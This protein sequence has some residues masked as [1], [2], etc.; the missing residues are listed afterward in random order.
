MKAFFTQTTGIGLLLFIILSIYNIVLDIED[1]M[2]YVDKIELIETQVKSIEKNS[3]IVLELQR[4][5]GLTSIYF[6]NFSQEHQQKMILQRVNS[7]KVIT[8]K[9]AN[10]ENSLETLRLL[11][12][13]K[14]DSRENIFDTYSELIRSLLL[15]TKSLTYGAEDKVL[16]NELITY[17]D[18]NSLQEILG[19]LRAKVGVVLSAGKMLKEQAEDI[20]RTNTLFQ[21]QLERTFI[22]DIL[23]SMKYTRQISKTQCLKKSLQTSQNLSEELIKEKHLSAIEWFSL[24]TCAIDKINSFVN[25]QI[26]IVYK[27]IDKSIREAQQ[28]RTKN[29]VIW[30]LG[31][32]VLSIFVYI[33]LKR[34]RELIKEQAMLRNYKKAIDLSSMVSI[35]DKNAL[36]THVNQN[37]C[38]KSGYGE[39]EFLGKKYNTIFHPDLSQKIT[40]DVQTH[41][42]KKEVYSGI[43]K[44]RT[45]DGQLFWADTFVVPILDDKEELVEYIT[46]GCDI[47]EILHLND[48]IRETQEELLYRLGEAVESRNKDSGQH[49]KRVAHYSKLLAQ[50]SNLSDDECKII[51]AA[52]SMHDVGKI[53]IPDKI[54]LKPGKLTDDEWI[55]MKTHAEIGYKL[56]KDSKRELLQVSADIAHEHHEFYDGNGYPRGL[57]G[58]EISI[59][60]RIVAITDVFDALCSKRPYKEPWELEKIL[61]LLKEG[62]GKQFD[63]HLI[64]LFVENIDEFLEIQ[65]SYTDEHCK[66]G[67]FKS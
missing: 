45:K 46:I 67:N 26:T 48:E 63:P 15:D 17:N 22:N 11:V 1:D 40:D 14:A 59:F 18:L 3:K 13:K 41:M 16:K 7:D 29:F 66:I 57:K 62:S 32:F 50:L 6:A 8:K 20:K 52:S 54:L 23:S 49:I 36:I 31:L 28:K 27:D 64:K 58:D 34:S 5:R 39:E 19:Q 25:Q 55:I 38:K 2:A 43:L 44:N 9:V 24:S 21:H 61:A 60:G 35:S 33:S 53:A 30:L 12:D 47:S 10:L 51:F 4:E 37:L 65:N 56:F 42:I